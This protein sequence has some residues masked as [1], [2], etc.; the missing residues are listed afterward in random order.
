M[1]PAQSV[2]LNFVLIH[3]NAKLPTYGSDG[4]AGFDFYACED[5]QISPGDCI[6]VPVGLI[7]EIPEGYE[8]QIRSRSSIGS[9]GVMLPHGV[10][11]VDFDYRG[12]LSI[13]L[14]NLTKEIF[15]IAQGQRIAQGLL[16]PVLRANIGQ[17]TR[18]QLSTT[19]RG[20]GG[21]GSTGV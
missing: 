20:S 18:E 12:E 3:P 1:G 13:P 7:A 9:S 19:S 5:Y 10:G 14:F 15:N 17:I 6:K 2:D 11:T 16:K 21:F 4:A 8:I